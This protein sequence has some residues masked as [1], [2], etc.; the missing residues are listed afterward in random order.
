MPE[1]LGLEIA[2]TSYAET[3]ERSLAWARSHES[4]ALFF[5]N[6]HVVMEAFDDLLFRDSLNRADMD[7][8]TNGCRWCG[9]CALLGC[10][11]HPGSMDRIQPWPCWRQQKRRMCL[12]VS[13]AAALRSSKASLLT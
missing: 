9:R 5:A 7:A 13:M 6:V 1:I 10:N 2:A 4:R 12:S 8:R 11:P 3:V